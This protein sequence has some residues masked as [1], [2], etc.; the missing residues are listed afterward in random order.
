MTPVQRARTAGFRASLAVRGVPLTLVPDLGPFS[1]L[2]EQYPSPQPGSVADS[3]SRLIDPEMRGAVRLAILREDLGL[4]QVPVG[5]VFRH[6]EAMTDYR[7]VRVDRLGIDIAE[8]FT[9]ERE[10]A[11]LE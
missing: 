5:S 8:R 6:V 7:V 10:D 1:A 3:G 2:V 9:C 11:P 4:T